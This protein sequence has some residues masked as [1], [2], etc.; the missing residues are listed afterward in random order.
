MENVYTEL[1]EACKLAGT[2]LTKVCRAAGVPRSTIERW[3]VNPRTVVIYRKIMVEIERAKI[4]KFN[5]FESD[6]C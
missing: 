1:E 6:E 5:K 3:K 2:N 4:A